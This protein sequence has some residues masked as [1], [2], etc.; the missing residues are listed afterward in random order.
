[1]TFPFSRRHFSIALCLSSVNIAPLSSSIH[2]D[3]YLSVNPVF[4]TV[5]LQV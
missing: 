1:L 2:D 5:H 4:F 3:L